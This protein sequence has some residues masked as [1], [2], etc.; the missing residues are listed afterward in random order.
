MGILDM[1][2]FAA[3]LRPVRRA[4]L[5]LKPW[6]SCIENLD[7]SLYMGNSRREPCALLTLESMMIC[8]AFFQK[9]GTGLGQSLEEKVCDRDEIAGV[10]VAFHLCQKYS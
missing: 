7:R 9:R 10:A 3:S 5:L 2:R 8:R 1:M 6:N 4:T